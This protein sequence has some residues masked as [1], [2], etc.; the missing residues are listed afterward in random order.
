MWSAGSVH[1][2]RRSTPAR[3][4]LRPSGPTI[5]GTGFAHS[6]RR[7]LHLQELTL[8]SAQP[9]CRG[10][11]VAHSARGLNL[12]RVSPAGPAYPAVLGTRVTTTQKVCKEGEV[13]LGHLGPGMRTAGWL[14]NF[15][16]AQRAGLA[17]VWPPL[18]LLLMPWA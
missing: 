8:G 14:S 18:P 11:G 3:A 10:V 12:Y 6:T 13:P 2:E 9:F 4:D 17:P 15:S 5:R 16:K 1:S 7:I